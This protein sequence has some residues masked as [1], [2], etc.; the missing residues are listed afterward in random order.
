MDGKSINGEQCG[1]DIVGPSNHVGG[2]LSPPQQFCIAI[3]KFSQPT[4]NQSGS[5]REAAAA[6]AAP[7]PPGVVDY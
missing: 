2:F 4:A 7:S 1:P 6:M 3:M 5:H